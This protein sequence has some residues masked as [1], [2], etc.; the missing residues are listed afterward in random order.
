MIGNHLLQGGVSGFF[1]CD[2]MMVGEKLVEN[3]KIWESEVSSIGYMEF[4]ESL[5]LQLC[6]G[7]YF[8]HQRNSD[9]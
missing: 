8:S 7:P 6:A 5:S 2:A 4:Y 3:L 1:N 9:S